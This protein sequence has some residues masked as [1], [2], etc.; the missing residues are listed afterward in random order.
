MQRCRVDC[1]NYTFSVQTWE[2]HTKEYVITDKLNCAEYAD[3]LFEANAN[4]SHFDANFGRSQ[5]FML[6]MGVF[7]LILGTFA[8]IFGA[9]QIFTYLHVC[10]MV[11]NDVS[12]FLNFG[13]RAGKP[14][15]WEGKKLP[16]TI[17][18]ITSS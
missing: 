7:F 2:Q 3:Q 6:I 8:C 4:F 18:W 16:L 14:D 12:V 10:L 9:R 15:V 5:L 1:C 11:L 13:T 17:N